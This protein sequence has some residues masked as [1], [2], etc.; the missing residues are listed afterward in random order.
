MPT[1]L[2]TVIFGSWYLLVFSTVN[3]A[4]FHILFSES[5]ITKPSS[6]LSLREEEEISTHIVGIFLLAKCTPFSPFI[7]ISMDSHIHNILWDIIE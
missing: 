5:E 6:C 7:Y 3:S 2:A 4:L 1:S